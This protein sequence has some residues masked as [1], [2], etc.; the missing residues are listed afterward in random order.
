MFRK[1]EQRQ[2]SLLFGPEMILSPR[3]QAQL[4]RSWAATFR[5]EV[6]E[7][8]DEELF[9]PLY[10]E[11]AS[12]PNAPV[13]VLMGF[14]IIKAGQGWSDEELYEALA[15]DI[16]LRYALGIEDMGSELPFTLR[17]LYNFRS[18]VQRYEREQGVNLYQKVFEQVTDEHLERY[19]VSARLQRMDSTQVMSNVAQTNRL[20]LLI[21]VL[22]VG[23]KALNKEAKAWWQEQA[24]YYLQKRAHEVVFGIRKEEMPAHFQKLGLLLWELR[25]ALSPDEGAYEVVERVLAEQYKEQEGGGLALREAEEIGADSLQ[26]PYDVDATFRKKNGKTYA[27]GYV[28]NVSETCAP[29]NELQLITDIQVAPNVTDDSELL[30]R[31]LH[32]QMERGHEIEE[33][34]T[35]GGY[36]GPETSAFCATHNIRHRPTHV[37]GGKSASDKL[38]WEAYTWDLEA[39]TA[40]CPQGQQGAILPARRPDRWVIH[41]PDEVQCQTCPLLGPCR[42]KLQKRNGPTLHVTTRNIE[43]A[44]IRQGLRPE[45]HSLR[46]AVEGTVRTLKW[47]LRKDKLPVRGLTAARMYFSAV[48]MM[49]NLRRIHAWLSS[50]TTKFDAATAVFYL[51]WALFTK[52]WLR[53]RRQT[54]S[55]RISETFR[56]PALFFHFHSLITPLPLL[57]VV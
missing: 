37:R 13:N 41:F 48:A 31:S 47:H 29:E 35:D 28:V 49:V 32:N 54:L 5:S 14:E 39:M 25:E 15:F 8:I 3:L 40:V 6:F 51:F 33:V 7:R 36:T 45:D 18:R 20:T 17:T 11:Q 34:T 53:A 24:G 38:G 46:S 43:V 16:R 52:I 12:R 27:G 50:I 56:P 22:Q 19:R 23:V 1:N 44:L 21:R 42:V 30:Q 9:A 10:S 57:F 55:E 4:Q 26:S 2:K